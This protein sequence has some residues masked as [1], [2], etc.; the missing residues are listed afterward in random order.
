MV[1]I[2]ADDENREPS[3][4]FALPATFR[5]K[6]RESYMKKACLILSLVVSAGLVCAPAA[7]GQKGQTGTAQ[8]SFMSKAMEMNQAEINLSRMAQSKAQ[9]QKVKDYA[10]MMVQDHT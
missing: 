9:D 5:N 4:C 1:S 8:D 6:Q 10:E 2:I 3:H 7:R